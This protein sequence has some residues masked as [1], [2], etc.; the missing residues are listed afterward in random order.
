LSR[1]EAVAV[2]GLALLTACSA[3]DGNQPQA[4]A[5]LVSV[6]P[7]DLSPPSVD[8]IDDTHVRITYLVGSCSTEEHALDLPRTI[9][10]EYTADEIVLQVDGEP[11]CSG[12]YEGIGYVRA[13][14]VELDEAVA[15]RSLR[16]E[17]VPR[18]TD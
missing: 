11:E 17:Q 7:T 13:A 8:V 9:E 18:A 10:I 2:L 16:I 4:E 14:I 5:T 15:G 1:V 12:V 6:L 3:G